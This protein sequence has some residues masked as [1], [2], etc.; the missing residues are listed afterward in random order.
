[1]TENER[2]S[3]IMTRALHAPDGL[4][5]YVFTRGMS[6]AD[7]L[8]FWNDAKALGLRVVGK[9]ARGAKVLALP[10]AVCE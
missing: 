1:M 10:S 3:L 6:K 2:R 4:T 7:A 9:S 8:Q 5:P